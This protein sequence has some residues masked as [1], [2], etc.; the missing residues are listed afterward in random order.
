[1]SPHLRGKGECQ[2]LE[3]AIQPGDVG[4]DMLRHHLHRLRREGQS[5]LKGEGTDVATDLVVSD[6]GRLH[7]EPHLLRQVLD[8]GEGSGRFLPA[9]EAEHHDRRR[10]RV[11][12]EVAQH[13][14]QRSSPTLHH[15]LCLPHHRKG[16]LR[17]HR[18]ATRRRQ[19]LRGRCR[20]AVE[21]GVIEVPRLLRHIGGLDFFLYLVGEVLLLTGE[22][23]DAVRLLGGVDRGEDTL[24]LFGVGHGGSDD[25]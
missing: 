15:R 6:L 10:D 20:G 13:L 12:D 24:W 11:I 21:E 18:C 22:Q 17:H 1:M 19:Q 23:I 9:L 4:P 8:H 14:H 5:V 16:I 3:L 7:V 25:F 2:L